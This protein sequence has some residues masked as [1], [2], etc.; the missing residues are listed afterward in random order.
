M[1]TLKINLE[2]QRWLEVCRKS[3]LCAGWLL[4]AFFV[5]N[6]ILGLYV[7]ATQEKLP[8]PVYL[9]GILADIRRNLFPGIV[10]LIVGQ[11]ISFL[12]DR[13]K[14]PR[15]L[16]RI[17]S[18]IFFMAALIKIVDMKSL[19]KG[20]EWA[21][22]EPGLMDWLLNFMMV[23]SPEILSRLAVIA[24]L[25]GLGYVLNH[26]IRIVEESKTLA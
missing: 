8:M 20:L 10:A 6:A 5:L 11:F 16:L 15:L 23:I 14:T 21:F 25:L 26:L 2:N 22:G 7:L 12:I 18:W 4:V 1:K 13:D 24:T 17:G 3:A 9:L 19:Y